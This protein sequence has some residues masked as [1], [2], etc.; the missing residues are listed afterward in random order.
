MNFTPEAARQQFPVFRQDESAL[1]LFFDGPGGSQVPAIVGEQITQY[2]SGGT[3]NVGGYY[4]TSFHTS[5]LVTQAREAGQALLNAPA[6]ENIVFG[7]NMTTLTFH[8]S[9]IISREW[10]SGDEVIVTELDHYANV[11]SWQ[12]AA[13]DRG[14][15]I[16]QAR[17]DENQC[18]LDVEH[19]LSLIG[20]RT[21][22]VAVTY[23][24]NTTGAIVDIR[25][26]IEAAHRV[27]AL[28]YVDA[29]HFAPHQ[30]IDV[31][32]LDCDFLVCSAYKFYGPHIGILYIA[33]RWL[34][35]FMPYKVEPAPNAGPGRYE[36]GT[37]NFEGLAGVIGAIEYLA[38]W[39]NAE[40]SL[41]MRLAESFTQYQQHE[42]RLAALFL[43]LTD[44]LTSAQLYGADV[45]DS[46]VRT[47]TF[48]LRF[49]HHT[50]AVIAKA[51]GEQNICVWHGHFYALGLVRRLGLESHGVLR[52]G[53]MHYN[54]E[55]EIHHLFE[56]L[57]RLEE[58]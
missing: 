56:H 16:R 55:A 2:L 47:P 30:L 42:Q 48:A 14:A 58:A 40:D 9:R 12:Q 23:A 1:P 52:I 10:Q 13:T 38:Q 4:P 28:V 25:R 39:G 35:H 37:L 41:R 46:A 36:T 49:A 5:R 29:V 17:V 50:P 19:L 11:S 51:L 22:L 31:Q 21:R 33:P 54:T 53:M 7:A 27:G 6:P 26:I 44:T 43:S 20:E 34:A 24:S 18:S 3:A 32:A 45:A 15:V 57:R 8:L